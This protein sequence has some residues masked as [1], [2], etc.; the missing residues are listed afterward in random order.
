[1]TKKRRVA[2]PSHL[3]HPSLIPSRKKQN[4]SSREA[5]PRAAEDSDQ[6]V[7]DQNSIGEIQ[8]SQEGDLANKAVALDEHSINTL[9]IKS[10]CRLCSSRFDPSQERLNGMVF[11]RWLDPKSTSSG[12][13]DEAKQS[14]VNRK[15]GNSTSQ[16]LTAPLG[17]FVQH[18][19]DKNQLPTPSP[20]QSPQHAHIA[21]SSSTPPTP[22]NEM[23]FNVTEWNYTGRL[24]DVFQGKLEYEGGSQ[25][26]VM[27]VMN[28]D[29]FKD[30]YGHFGPGGEDE[31]FGS[32]SLDAPEYDT[33]ESAIEA[34][35]NEDQKYKQLSNIKV[36]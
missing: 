18:L 13:I 28:P 16:S 31:E 30:E 22:E 29:F 19:T 15:N 5:P 12:K 2:D 10:A 20:S 7:K 3:L 35:Y 23:T 17:K 24:W 33:R 27:K 21:S 8:G 36:T 14:F 9:K 4:L 6:E 25:S 1:M 34:V 32:Y 26:L 11:Q